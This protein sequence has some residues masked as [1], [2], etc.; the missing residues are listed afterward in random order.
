MA[1]GGPLPTLMAELYG[2]VHGQS[3]GKAGSMHLAAPQVGVMGAS[4]VVGSTISVAVG[5]ALASRLLKK[6]QLSV[7][8]YGDGATE[9][10]S[11]HEALNLASIYQ[12]PCLFLCENNGLAVHAS[13]A[14]RQSYR[15]LTHAA[16]YGLETVRID[17]GW[18]FV[19]I[20]DVTREVVGAMRAD[21]KPRVMEIMTCRYKEHVGPGE[22]F[23]AGYRSRAS[24]EDWMAKDPLCVD[25]ALVAELKPAIDAEIAEAVAFAEASPLPG[26]TELLTDVY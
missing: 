1:K 13:L 12:L 19:K 21:G 16:A 5:A 10:G 6:E 14:E 15:I 8:C 24:V 2:R 17:E 25:T 7:V 23:N 11:Y 18:D 22:D 3:Q 26:L 9:Q 4:A 20:A